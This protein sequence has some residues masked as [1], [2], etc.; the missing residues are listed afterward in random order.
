MAGLPKTRTNDSLETVYASARQPDK[1]VRTRFAKN[2][3]GFA[4]HQSRLGRI[5]V[6]AMRSSGRHMADMSMFACPSATASLYS[7]SD[8]PPRSSRAP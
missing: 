6:A 5:S 7:S 1:R 3:A 2:R 8:I 4:A